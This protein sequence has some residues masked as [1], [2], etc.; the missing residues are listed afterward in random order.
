[1]FKQLRSSSYQLRHGEAV[2]AELVG[3]TGVRV[4]M[5]YVS[6]SRSTYV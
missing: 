4:S 2:L 1:M 6:M 3:G 5:F